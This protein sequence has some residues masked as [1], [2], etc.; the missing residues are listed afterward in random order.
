MDKI[1]RKLL[2]RASAALAALLLAGTVAMAATPPATSPRA[3]VDGFHEVLL[4][5][6]KEAKALG[7]AQRFARIEPEIARRFD[8]PLMIALA[9][10]S[11]WRQAGPADRKRLEDAFRR[12][13][14]ANYASQFSDY[15]GESFEIL[16]VQPGPR[17]TQLVQT[18][19]NRPGD[20]PVAI[21]YVTRSDGTGWHIVDVLVDHGIS[22][23][24]VRRSEYS[25]ILKNGGVD[26]LVRELEAKT[27]QLLKE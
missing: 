9:A 14:A 21:T 12:F 24:A 18:R 10:G 15:S 1:L 11:H 17:N 8:V 2:S 7:A 23:L 5:V 16:G 27:A 3:L 13:S 22:E 6:M 19:L 4:T 25:S 26:A 20:T